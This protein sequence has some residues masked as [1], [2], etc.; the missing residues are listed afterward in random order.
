MKDFDF[1]NIVALL[2]LIIIFMFLDKFTSGYRLPGQN[3]MVPVIAMLVLA[4]QAHNLNMKYARNILLG[5]VIML[6]FYSPSYAVPGSYDPRAYMSL[7]IHVLFFWG[8]TLAFSM[9]AGRIL[10]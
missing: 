9:V 1:T 6:A 10:G 3:I 5:L 4:Y 7:V 8:L 2:V